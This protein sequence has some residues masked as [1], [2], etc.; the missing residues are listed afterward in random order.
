M[1]KSMLYHSMADLWNLILLMRKQVR[2]GVSGLENTSRHFNS[3]MLL[4]SPLW[5]TLYLKRSMQ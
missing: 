4:F 2:E 3:S 1:R 5:R